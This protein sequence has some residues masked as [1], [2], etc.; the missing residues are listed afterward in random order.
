M[1]IPKRSIAWSLLNMR[2]ANS[3]QRAMGAQ[4]VIEIYGIRKNGG[5]GGG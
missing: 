1:G 5:S 2:T 3:Q 4:A